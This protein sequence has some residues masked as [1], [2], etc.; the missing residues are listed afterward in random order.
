M[1]ISHP[2]RHPIS[3]LIICVLTLRA[4]SV[5][6]SESSAYPPGK[7]EATLVAS[8]YDYEILDPLAAFG[9]PYGGWSR[10]TRS[11][12]QA[13]PLVLP[14]K[15]QDDGLEQTEP[16]YMQ[17]RDGH[18]QQYACRVYEERELD[19]SSLSDSLFDPP[20]LRSEGRDYSRSQEEVDNDG[21]RASSG[22]KTANNFEQNNIEGVL[23]AILINTRLGQL[24]GYCGHLYMGW[25]S[26]EWCFEQYISQFHIELDPASEK[27]QASDF[28]RLGEFHSRSITTDP[29]SRPKNLLA[30]GEV[31]LAT[32]VE[33]YEGGDIC[34]ETGK[35]RSSTVTII[36]CSSDVISTH[37]NKLPTGGFRQ[38]S[39]LQSNVVDAALYSVRERDMCTYD[40][41]VC[42]SLLCAGPSTELVPN[43]NGKA[44][45]KIMSGTASHPFAKTRVATADESVREILDRTLGSVCLQSVPGGW[46]TYEF[47][48][49]Q[50]IRQYRDEVGRKLS[51]AGTV[52]TSQVEA[53]H[54]LGKH[55]S[56]VA[57]YPNEDELKHVVNATSAGKEL[58]KGG[59]GAYF[60]VE[61]LGG[62]VCAESEVTNR[63]IVAGGS[64]T[65]GDEIR[66]TS[67]VRYSCGS[68]FFLSVRE[69]S[70]CHYIVDVSLPD[71]CSH[72]LFKAP[73]TSRQVVKCL[74]VDGERDRSGL[75]L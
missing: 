52:F 3:I 43:D 6:G 8:E 30:S 19:P 48:H 27:I 71:L 9:T 15:K 66:R 60:Q 74:P 14:T 34:P 24:K 31:E 22:E 16:A 18:G 55:S 20:K 50:H 72:A 49:A 61:Y 41:V 59:N 47:C 35:F 57:A 64:V 53:E 73:M 37:K 68:T 28:T 51:A 45:V 1:G 46:W 13:L 36:C 10:T 70:T 40:L 65:A 11:R 42:T 25:W 17:V 4:V 58:G 12:L 39:G 23:S 21:T 5:Q 56:T 33:K 67:A 62:D 7:A 29:S 2:L 75:S 32:I 44:K 63:A 54:L 38:G 69:D 26:Y